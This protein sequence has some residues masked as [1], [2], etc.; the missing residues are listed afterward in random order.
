MSRAII[1]EDCVCSLEELQRHDHQFEQFKKYRLEHAATCE[2]IHDAA[3]KWIAANPS[4]INDPRSQ[5]TAFQMVLTAA[6]INANALERRQSTI[7]LTGDD[8]AAYRHVTTERPTRAAIRGLGVLVWLFTCIEIV[9]MAASWLLSS[10]SVVV[11]VVG[12]LL[13]G[14]SLVAGRGLG[15]LLFKW[16][17]RPK[18]DRDAGGGFVDWAFFIVGAVAASIFS[19]LRS[20]GFRDIGQFV[21][22]VTFAILI[23]TTSAAHR[24][25]VERYQQSFL[26]YFAGEEFHATQGHLRDYEEARALGL[27]GFDVTTERA[28]NLP[29]SSWV[30]A[31]VA[32]V[33]DARRHL[34]SIVRLD[35]KS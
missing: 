33:E 15:G 7:Y 28:P 23:A 32:G 34:E 27:T 2:V 16:M 8:E 35:R 12:V 11:V 21:F 13:A 10:L 19:A 6:P 29:N 22:G 30:N 5:H 25:F 1:G 17:Q 31:F 9:I 4:K 24:L 20:D 18:I 3:K 26:R 14:A